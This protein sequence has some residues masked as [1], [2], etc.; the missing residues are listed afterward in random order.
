MVASEIK[1]KLDK[2][3]KKRLKKEKRKLEALSTAEGEAEEE[4][5]VKPK[6]MKTNGEAVSS[7]VSL[8]GR[9]SSPRCW[10]RMARHG[11][12]LSAV[13]PLP[14]HAV[15]EKTCSEPLTGPISGSAH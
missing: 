14:S 11:N 12:E 4:E 8:G 7:Q 1:R 13:V 15:P 5:E 6:K 9:T 10:A 2:K 3:E